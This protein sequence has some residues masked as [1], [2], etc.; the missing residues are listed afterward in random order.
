MAKKPETKKLAAE[1]KAAKP[2]EPAKEKVQPLSR[3]IAELLVDSPE[4][5]NMLIR[6]IDGMADKNTCVQRGKAL[7][8]R[9]K[10]LNEKKE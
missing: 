4:V 3:E 9:Y 5:V 10:K 8:E 7:L 6:A 1:P 2:K